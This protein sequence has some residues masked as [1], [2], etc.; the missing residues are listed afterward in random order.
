MLLGIFFDY[1]WREWSREV[2]QPTQ[3]HM[4]YYVLE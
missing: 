1:E 4:A 3:G 2:K